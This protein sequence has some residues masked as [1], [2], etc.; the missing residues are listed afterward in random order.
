MACRVAGSGSRLDWKLRLD[1]GRAAHSDD[2][3]KAQFVKA[4]TFRHAEFINAAYQRA[5]NMADGDTNRYARILREF[6]LR[7]CPIKHKI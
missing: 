5:F 1:G 2:E 6:P 7:N 3:V 4:G